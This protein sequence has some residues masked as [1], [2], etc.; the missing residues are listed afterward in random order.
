[1]DIGGT[2]RLLDVIQAFPVFILAMVLVAIAA[3][4]RLTWFSQSL[5]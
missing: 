4:D 5:S 2:L 3:P 1:M